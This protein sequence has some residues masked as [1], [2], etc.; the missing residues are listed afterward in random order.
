MNLRIPLIVLGALGLSAFNS[1]ASAPD[2]AR[3]QGEALRALQQGRIMPLPVIEN[4]IVPKMRGFDYLGPEF[5]P[6][7]LRYR[8][9]FIRQGRVVWVDVDARTGQIV[10]HSG[11]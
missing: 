9:K 4:R 7:A 11:N 10:G 8:L 2:Q 1:P 6:G 3:E 5:D